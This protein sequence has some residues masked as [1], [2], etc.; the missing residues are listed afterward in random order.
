MLHREK[1]WGALGA[2]FPATAGAVGLQMIET[3]LE[4]GLELTMV[5]KTWVDLE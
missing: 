2:T 1:A 5:N 4:F 3:C